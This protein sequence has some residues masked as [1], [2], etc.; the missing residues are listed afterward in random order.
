MRPNWKMYR[1]PVT[2]FAYPFGLWNKEAIPEVKERI[3]NGIYPFGPK[4]FSDPFTIRRMIVSGTWTTE[5]MMNST[6]PL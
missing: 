3:P 4:R 6:E 1:K 5:G 2:Y